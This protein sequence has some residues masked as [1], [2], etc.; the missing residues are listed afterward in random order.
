VW[1]VLTKGRIR[2]SLSTGKRAERMVEQSRLDLEA[3]EA[4]VAELSQQAAELEARMHDELQ[5]LN[6]KWVEALQQIQP[7]QITPK[8][9]DIRVE[10][11][12]VGWVPVWQVHAG[13][14]T[15]LLPAFGE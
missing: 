11:F 8:K 2:R 14:E 7:L 15:V 1:D 9:S 4:R 5:G 13:A 12:G 6:D 3:S 10:L